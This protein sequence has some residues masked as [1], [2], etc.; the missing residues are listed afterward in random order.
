MIVGAPLVETEGCARNPPPSGQKARGFAASFQQ[1]YGLIVEG[2]EGL[3]A[4]PA[5][6]ERVVTA[7]TSAFMV[8]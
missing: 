5:A 4:Q 1:L 2:D 3:R 7:I 6:F 8:T